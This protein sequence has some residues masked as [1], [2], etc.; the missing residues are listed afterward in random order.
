GAYVLRTLGVELVRQHNAALAG[1][2][3]ATIG[4]ALGLAPT[5][6]PQHI[7]DA[8]LPMRVVPLPPGVAATPEAANALRRRIADDLQ[9][10]TAVNSWRGRGWLRL[11][12]QVYNRAD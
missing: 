12:A 8:G 5:E 4:D 6:L 2:A 3:Q 10:E 11:S 1:Y 7:G 9:T